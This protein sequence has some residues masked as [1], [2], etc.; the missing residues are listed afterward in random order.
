[1]NEQSEGKNKNNRR[2]FLKNLGLIG[3]GAVAGGAAIYSG[4]RFEKSKDES[5]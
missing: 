1:M 4:Y 5:G 2:Q 3:T